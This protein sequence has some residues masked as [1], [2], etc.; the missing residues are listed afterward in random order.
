MSARQFSYSPD[1]REEH[2][3][4]GDAGVRRPA[5]V[6][7]GTRL[8]AVSAADPDGQAMALD[9]QQVLLLDVLRRAGGEPVSYEELR[10]AGV[11]YPASV[12]SEL[13]LAGLPVDRCSEGSSAA[14]RLRGA[15]PDQRRDEL[16]DGEPGGHRQAHQ[17]TVVP[18]GPAPAISASTSP[19]PPKRHLRRAGRSRVA[20]PTCNRRTT[21]GPRLGAGCSGQRH[22]ASRT[23]SPGPR[24]RPH[25][26]STRAPLA[27]PVAPWHSGLAR[28]GA[29]RRHFERAMARARRADRRPRRRHDPGRRRT[30]RQ[31]AG[32]PRRRE[33][34]SEIEHPD[35]RDTLALR[36]AAARPLR[37]AAARP[38]RAAAARPL[39]AANSGLP[40][41]GRSTRGA[42]ARTAAGRRAQE[43]GPGPQRGAGRNRREPRQMRRTSQRN[44]PD[45]C[46]RAL[47]PGDSASARPPAGR[48][49]TDP[50]TAPTDRQPAAN[51]AGR[52]PTGSPRSGPPTGGHVDGWL[53]G[54]RRRR[55]APV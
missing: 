49:S 32:T 36:A 5:G 40:H 33:P 54:V 8:G 23:C 38:L 21:R 2:G 24:P 46:L 55:E 31:R 13:E 7:P 19:R 47:R 48:R 17:P 10:D 29:P 16:P 51:R 15:R 27:E 35:G 4:D 12:V 41:A 28:A 25:R 11:E 50:R 37:A 30:G 45:L 18:D 44:M 9:H 14:C 22:R 43:R 6:S 26:G 34:S 42:R 3:S 20:R 52:A 1:T 53:T 39:H